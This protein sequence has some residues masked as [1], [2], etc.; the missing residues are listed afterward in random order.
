MTDIDPRVGLAVLNLPLGSN[1]VQAATVR[2]YLI[3]LLTRVWAENEEFSGKRP[4]GN[5]DWQ[6]DVYGALI[7]GGL[8]PGVHVNEI[9]EVDDLDTH[10]ADRYILAAITALGRPIDLGNPL[11]WTPEQ[12]RENE[13]FNANLAPLEDQ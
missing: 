4:F 3:A 11:G 13:E 5:D 7:S 6:Y 8:L 9:G 10:E 1:E 2:D 12:I